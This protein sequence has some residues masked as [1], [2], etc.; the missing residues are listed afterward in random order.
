M[1]T[2]LRRNPLFLTDAYN[3][4]HERLKI[5]TDF[6]VSHIYNRKSDM[7]L[8]GF[9]ELVVSFLGSI[10][11]TDEMISEAAERAKTFGLTF[12][13]A[14]FKR[15][16][17]ELDGRVP[18]QVQCL[19]EGTY[20]PAGTPF[21]QIRNTVKG[22]GELVT[23]WEAIFLHGYFSSSC[24]TEAH[25]MRKYLDE[26]REKFNFPETFV[27]RFHSFGFRGHRSLEDAYWAGSAWSLFLSGSDDFHISM[28]HPDCGLSSISA[29]AHKVTQQF[30]NEYDC[31][32][33]AIHQT[34]K[35]G[36][37]I[38]SLVIDTYD[39]YN[40]I[41]NMVLRLSNHAARIGIHVVYRPDSGDVLKQAVDIYDIVKEN[42]L[43]NVSVIIGE[44]MSLEVAKK[45][46][47][48]FR[49][50]NVP[51]N[52]VNYGIGAGFYKHIERDT[53]GWAMKTAFS[54][55]KPC[56][57]FSEDPLK[58]STPGIVGIY[59]DE[60]NEMVV[61]LEENFKVDKNG[62]ANGNGKKNEYETIYHYVPDKDFISITFPKISTI[63]QHANKQLTDQLYIKSS[64]SIKHLIK[65]F[66]E[67]YRK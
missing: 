46:D 27:K 2:E 63:R 51:L 48:F 64:A 35:E 40:V 1:Y 31:F 5:N 10:R 18:L 4:S 6:E 57:K 9:H 25:Q 43:H 58:R 33:H 37:K 26:T 7:I 17:T 42:D 15:V 53:L 52:F 49:K 36:G 12:P 16:V 32:T 56:M 44:G 62:N 41:R 60:H 30:D 14:M 66:K 45:A 3:L 20:C 19:P 28:H 23:W 50:N 61:D 24:A 38:V 29:L 11:I 65:Q 13:S 47:L 59:Y 8:F 21:A 55:G 22:F 34:E 54:N 67:K 39:T